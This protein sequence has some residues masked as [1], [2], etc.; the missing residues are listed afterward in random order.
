MSVAVYVAIV[1]GDQDE[2][3]SAFFPDLPGCVTAAETMVELPT[4]ARDA[5]ALHLQ[6]MIEDGDLFP[7][8]TPIE[9]IKV[10]AEVQEIGR[11]II[12][13]EIQ[14]TPVRVNISIGAQFLRRVDSAAEVRGMSRSGFLV[15][16]ARL[17]L[18]QHSVSDHVT[19]EAPPGF[20][21]AHASTFRQQAGEVW[22]ASR[23]LI[24]PTETDSGLAVVW[25][26]LTEQVVDVVEYSSSA[27][28][29]V[30]V[31]GVVVRFPEPAAIR[32]RSPEPIVGSGHALPAPKTRRR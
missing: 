17:M 19:A 21:E 25:D 30:E 28:R 7:N 8:P 26:R 31:G 16:S 2:G 14:D 32:L 12:D 10:D 11:L 3:Y 4:A 6:G 20:S 1:E 9:D 13:A 5:L 27:L 22:D 23:F 29:S 18:S 24:V 15:E